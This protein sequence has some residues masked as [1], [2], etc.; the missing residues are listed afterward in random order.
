[1]RAG[2][3]YVLL[4]IHAASGMVSLAFSSDCPDYD[5]GSGVIDQFAGNNQTE[6]DEGG[7]FLQRGIGWIRGSAQAV[8]EKTAG[9]IL[10]IWTLLSFDYDWWQSSGWTV[11]DYS[12][13]LL[14]ACLGILQVVVITQIISSRRV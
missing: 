3:F 2:L 8:W 7:N 11:I 6:S 13:N 5:C 4:A 12:V 1:M 9:I 10:P 14:R